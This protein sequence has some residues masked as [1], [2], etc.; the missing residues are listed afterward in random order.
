MRDRE[1]SCSAISRANLSHGAFRLWHA[2]LYYRDPFFGASKLSVRKASEM[3]GAEQRSVINWIKELH[4]NGWLLVDK[5]TAGKPS[6]YQLMDGCGNAVPIEEE[7]YEFFH[8]FHG[9]Q[10]P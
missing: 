9:E 1:Q 10:K 6:Q 2:I 8:I 3:I 5:A 4:A 7:D